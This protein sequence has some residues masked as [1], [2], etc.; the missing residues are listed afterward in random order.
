MKE[1]ELA[2]QV[3][4]KEL[5]ARAHSTPEPV[6]DKHAKFDISKHVRF[7]PPFQE[8]EIDKYFLHFE[9][10]ATSLDWPKDVWT[11]LLQSVLVGK[12][13]E[14]YAALSVDQSS[15]YETVKTAIL[16]AYEV[17]EAY[18]QKF[19]ESKKDNGQTYVE[20]AR[21]KERLF[22]RWCA[23]MGVNNDFKKLRELMLLEEFK[24]CMPNEI[25]MYLEEQKLI[26]LHQ[27]AVRSDDYSLTHKLAFGRAAHCEGKTTGVNTHQISSFSSGIEADRR[28][29]RF[30]SGPTCFYCKRKGHVMAECQALER[31]HQRPPKSDLLIKPA[32]QPPNGYGQLDQQVDDVTRSCAPFI[33]EGSVCLAGQSI[34]TPVK[35]LRDTGATQ[36]LILENVLPFS[37]V[38]SCRDSVLLQGIELGT[39]RVPLH[40]VEL[41]SKLVSGL[42]V[43]GVRSSLPV[44]GIQL[45]LGNDLA[46]GKV[47]ANR[48]VSGIPCSSGSNAVEAIP[49]LFPAC[50]VTRAMAKRAM[51]HVQDDTDEMV[52]EEQIEPAVVTSLAPLSSSLETAP[53]TL[54]ESI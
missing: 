34:K 30:P 19:R 7:V 32:R 33:S 44:E 15:E 46:G 37:S 53:A 21:N 22:D 29:A 43:V 25:K 13:R 10:V 12:A 8:Q 2:L 3:K 16:N 31:K 17:P 39:V 50:A 35:I 18:R 26:T 28:T 5:E 6:T 4:L 47:E 42:V 48:C 20:F 36:T 52:E 40:R 54:S 14:V 27:A 41:S 1:K 23:S 49:G 51:N 9:K 38:S 11:F 45:V 24:N